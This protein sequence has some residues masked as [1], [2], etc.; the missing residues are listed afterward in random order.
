MTYRILTGEGNGLY[1][2]L[3][4]RF[5]AHAVPVTSVEEAMM[6]VELEREKYH[7][8]RHCC[9]AY[10]VGIRE[11][12]E[13]CSDDGEPSSTAGK[14]I[15]GR[16][17]SL[18]LTNVV[19]TVVR[20]FGGK[21]LGTSGLIIAYRTAAEAALT[22][23][24]K[25]ARRLRHEMTLRFPYDRINSIIMLMRD[26]AVETLHFTSDLEGYIYQVSVEDRHLREF[27]ADAER[28]YYLTIDDLH[29]AED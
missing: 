22:D 27:L 12:E 19:V 21:L 24:P 28:H 18:H 2:E 9:W 26:H 25:E 1:S 20:Y 5:I 17:H 6:V 13:R 10:V 4:S 8:A 14:P 16:I 23:A 3:R 29:P 15:L 11:C 7:D